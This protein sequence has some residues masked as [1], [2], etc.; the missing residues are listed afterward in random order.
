MYFIYIYI[1]YILY[2]IL[3]LYLLYYII[4]Y[5]F[6]IIYLFHLCIYLY[7]RGKNFH[8]SYLHTHTH[9]HTHTKI[10]LRSFTISH[11]RHSNII[12][13]SFIIILLDVAL[14]GLRRALITIAEFFSTASTADTDGLC[15]NITY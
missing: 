8:Y 9:T 6:I 13:A 14:R 12:S 7:I 1:I 10:I 2:I 4:L 15:R 3:C 5:I 11:F